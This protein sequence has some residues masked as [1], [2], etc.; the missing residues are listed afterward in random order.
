MGIGRLNQKNSLSEVQHDLVVNDAKDSAIDG[1]N[2]RHGVVTDLEVPT[3]LC[4]VV[5]SLAEDPI[6]LVL[7]DLVECDQCIAAFAL[8][9]LCEDSVFIV[10]AERV[11]QDV[12]LS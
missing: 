11:H 1:L 7:L 8:Q 6:V 10:L 3:N 5:L 2:T 4:M 9:C 12:W